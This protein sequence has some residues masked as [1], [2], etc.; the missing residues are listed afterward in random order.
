MAHLRSQNA[1]GNGTETSSPRA[2][3]FLPPWRYAVLLICFTIL[4]FLLLA[5]GLWLVNHFGF[6]EIQKVDDSTRILAA[7]IALAGSLAGSLATL[8]GL[9]LKDA[10]DHRTLQLKELTEAQRAQEARAA[11]ERL[12]MDTCVKAVELMGPIDDGS[13]ADLRRAGALMALNSLGQTEFALGLLDEVWSQNSVPPTTAVLLIENALASIDPSLQNG[14]AAT[15][16]KHAERLLTSDG[17]F[18]W[19]KAVAVDKLCLQAASW[20][21]EALIRCLLARERDHWPAEP[22]NDALVLAVQFMSHSGTRSP[23]AQAANVISTWVLSRIERDDPSA[24]FYAQV[25]QTADSIISE[26]PTFATQG[27]SMPILLD[28]LRSWA[29]TPTGRE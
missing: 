28:S 5:G 17:G 15:L 23:A 7:I 19:P 18:V 21:L 8:L 1:L 24:A 27:G 20:T 11:E 2:E 26:G 6:V 16:R 3:H 29:S 13:S 10:M 14:A 25:L 12:R 22:I 9:L 4:F